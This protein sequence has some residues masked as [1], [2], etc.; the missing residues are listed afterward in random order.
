MN[1]PSHAYLATQVSQ[2]SPP[3][4][5]VWMGVVNN[6]VYNSPF[7]V[8]NV[9]Y[10]RLS[11]FVDRLWTKS[12]W[13][14]RRSWCPV[15]SRIPTV[16]T[17]HSRRRHPQRIPS[18]ARFAAHPLHTPNQQFDEEIGLLSTL[19]PLPMTTTTF[20][21]RIRMR[22]T[23]HGSWWTTPVPSGI[24]RQTDEPKIRQ[25]GSSGHIGCARARRDTSEDQS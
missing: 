15:H 20:H 16:H 6:H 24:A 3:S 11:P 14:R 23:T 17:G 8:R 2:I 18:T 7:T 10:V 21:H 1:H 22:T 12:S 5:Q 9:D 25:S 4:P 19:S 13:I